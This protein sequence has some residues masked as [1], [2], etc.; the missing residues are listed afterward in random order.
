MRTVLIASLTSA[1]GTADAHGVSSE[2][3]RLSSLATLPFSRGCLA[4]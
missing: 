4:E 3:D 1:S 2:A